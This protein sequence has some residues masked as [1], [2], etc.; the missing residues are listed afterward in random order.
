MKFHQKL[1]TLKK[2]DNAKYKNTI[3]EKCQNSKLK[4]KS[5]QSRLLQ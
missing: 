5:D 3:I 2:Y 1:E 4:K